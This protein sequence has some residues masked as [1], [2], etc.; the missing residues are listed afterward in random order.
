MMKFGKE[1]KKNEKTKALEILKDMRLKYN[2]HYVE[3]SDQVIKLDEAIDELEELKNRKRLTRRVC[4][5]CK[6][7]H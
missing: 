1:W 2:S 5:I 7:S 3:G 6:T 4:T